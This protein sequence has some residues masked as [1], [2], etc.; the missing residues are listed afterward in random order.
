MKTRQRQTV[1]CCF[2]VLAAVAAVVVD[3]PSAAAQVPSSA[4]TARPTH[5]INLTVEQQHVI[6]EIIVKELKFKEATQPNTPDAVGET[7]PSGVVL[8]PIP[9][10]VSVKVPQVRTHSFF[11]KDSHIFV[12]DPKDNKVAEVVK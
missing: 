9:V 4:P 1:I 10:E 5:R 7:V 8:H 2:A 3:V 11:I 6:R 12:V